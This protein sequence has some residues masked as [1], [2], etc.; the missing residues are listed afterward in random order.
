VLLNSELKEAPRSGDL[1]PARRSRRR[2]ADQASDA[3]AD[4]DPRRAPL[5]E[6][7]RARGARLETYAGASVVGGVLRS[8]RLAHDEPA[9]LV[10]PHSQTTV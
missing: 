4:H 9:M 5:R 10:L 8:G 7:V 2:R 3:A 1:A 6:R